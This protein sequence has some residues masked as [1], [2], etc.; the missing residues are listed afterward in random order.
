M[1]IDTG[2]PD[3]GPCTEE[4]SETPEGPLSDGPHTFR[5]ALHRRKPATRRRRPAGLYS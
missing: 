4:G 5:S 1:P 2:T 3:F